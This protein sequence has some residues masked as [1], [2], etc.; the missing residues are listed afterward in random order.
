MKYLGLGGLFGALAMAASAVSLQ[1][2]ALRISFAESEGGYAVVGIE[3]RLAD[4]VRFVNPEARDSSGFWEAAFWRD[5]TGGQGASNV[6]RLTNLSPCRTKRVERR[7]DGGATFVW[8]GL[9]LPGEKGIAT[10]RATVRFDADGTSRWSLDIQNASTVWGLA[11]TKYPLLRHVTKSGEADVLQPRPDLG[12]RLI[13]NRPWSKRWATAGCMGYMPM[14]MAF[15]KGEA[16]LYAAAHDGEARI[17]T[18]GL[19]PEHDYMFI[20]PVENAGCAGTAAEGPRYEVTIAA[21]KGDWWEAARLY[22]SWALTT[23]WT[24]RGRII[25]RTDYPT[26]LAEMPLWI[27]I[28]GSP[29]EVSNVMT[30]AR[31]L[32]PNF[33]AGIHWHLWQHSPH[34][35]NYPEYFPEQPGTKE[36]L[37]YCRSIGQEAMPYTNGRLWS[38]P[39]MSYPYVK[40]FAIT[41]PDGEPK[42]E[43]YG[44]VTPP[45]VPMCPYTSHWDDTLNDFSARVLALGASS[46]FLDQIG[47]CPGVACY[48]TNHGHP[49]GGGTWYFEGYQ[50][51]LAKTHAVYSATNAFLTTEGSG[52]QWMNVV[53]GYLNVTQ[54]Q[55]DD[56]PF[57]HAVYSGYTTY[58]C[59]PENHE[60]DDA[61]FRC[62]QTRELLWGQALGWYHPFIL[63]SPSKCGILRTLCEF[64]QAHL[65]CFAYGTLL[66]E[67]AFRDPVP[68]QEFTWLGRKP[69]W[70]W[71][72]PD[73]P[74]SATIKGSLPSLYGYVWKS[75]TS[76]SEMAFLANLSAES[77]TVHFTWK[78]V[79]RT[80]TL[81]A[82]AV[83]ALDL[84]K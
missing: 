44:P 57:F 11:E 24:A 48:A 6:V 72:M 76:G 74:L 55:A 3:N 63:D 38:V 29:A 50:R 78:G 30:R 20:T 37:A 45:L 28:H 2:D 27:N 47:A 66:G 58:F 53:D 67:V 61:S 8:E 42:T 10:A 25:D 4:G 17:K 22:R 16:G 65:D 9:D 23:K 18:Q 81:A 59:S 5:G 82:Y 75:A 77:K 7:A 33:D 12:A 31:A 70:A 40:P 83:M 69:F 32:F 49:V 41:K 13:R 71:K 80:A 56:V 62:A 73:Y 21:F 79:A 64:R 52:E 1:N 84:S 51:I 34:D 36:C 60:D 68:E 39:L 46:L 26:H 15:M 19:S 43:K 35:V 14:M 54:R